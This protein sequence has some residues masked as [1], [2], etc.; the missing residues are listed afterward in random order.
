MTKPTITVTVLPGGKVQVDAAGYKGKTCEEA[1]AWVEQ[2]LGTKEGT[3]YKPE[4]HQ[5]A[6]T[7]S[8]Q[9]NSA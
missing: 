7:S 1:T 2:L 5:S 3:A 8:D 4:Y 6:T 9:K